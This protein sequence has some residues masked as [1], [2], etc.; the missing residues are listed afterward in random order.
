VSDLLTLYIYVTHT[1][2]MPQLKILVSNF[3]EIRLVEAEL[4]HVDCGKY[5]PTWQT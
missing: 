3:M 4:C 2:G 1:T 5:R